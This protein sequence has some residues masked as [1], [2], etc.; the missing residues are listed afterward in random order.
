MNWLRNAIA[1]LRSLF[2]RKRL[3]RSRNVTALPPQLDPLTLYVVG[4]NGHRWHVAMICPCG[5]K[6]TLFM[7]LLPD[8]EPCW[9]LSEHKDGSASLHPSVWRKVGCRSHFWLR[10]GQIHW[11]AAEDAQPDPRD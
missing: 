2:T 4:Q 3:I 8:E 11:C 10:D 9:E 5:C 6:A 1:W 7:N